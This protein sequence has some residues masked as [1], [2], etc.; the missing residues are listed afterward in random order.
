MH[1]CVTEETVA[2]HIA[3][4]PV[5]TIVRKAIDFDRQ[6]VLRAEEVKRVWSDAMLAAELEAARAKAELLPE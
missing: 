1:P 4:R 6:P 5:A 2:Q 3:H